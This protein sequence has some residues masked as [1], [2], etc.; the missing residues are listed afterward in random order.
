MKKI[1]SFIEM[2]LPAFSQL[3]TGL[4]QTSFLTGFFQKNIRPFQ[5]VKI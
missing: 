2:I 5:T 4:L 1:F 3:Q